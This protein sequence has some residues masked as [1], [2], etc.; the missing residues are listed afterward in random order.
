MLMEEKPKKKYVKP[1]VRKVKLDAKTAVL[2]F[3][4]TGGVF[5]PQGIGCG[6]PAPCGAP[7]S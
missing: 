4:K 5:G 2:G 7:G 6:L 1:T 3:C